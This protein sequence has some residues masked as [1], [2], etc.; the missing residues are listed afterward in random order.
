MQ[1]ILRQDVHLYQLE[2]YPDKDQ[3]TLQ[4]KTSAAIHTSAE[5]ED[6]EDV[7]ALWGLWLKVLSTIWIMP[8]VLGST[9][10]N[11]IGSNQ[12]VRSIL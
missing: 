8:Y 7:V 4:F 6:V 5:Y 11:V 9:E 3:I 1:S 12:E 10:K 2:V